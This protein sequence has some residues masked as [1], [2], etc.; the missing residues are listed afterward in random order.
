MKNTLFTLM[1]LVAMPCLKAQTLDDKSF[2]FWLGKWDL[3]WTGPNGTLEKGTNHIHTIMDGK[4]IQ[5]NFE[6]LTGAQKGFKG[7]SIS[8]YTPAS[9]SW[10]QT[11]MDNQSSNI[12]L[13]GAS[14]GDKRIF[15]TEEVVVNGKK[16][17]SRMVFYD[18]T[19]NSFTWDWEQSNDKEL[20]WNLGW[21]I[22]YKRAQD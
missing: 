17:T 12:N 6:A 1:I 21:R 13:M 20:T 9:K 15:Q 18:I 16:I 19:E 10:H 3:T 22:N 5:E 2:D 11:W 7:I 14:D 8:V 4:V